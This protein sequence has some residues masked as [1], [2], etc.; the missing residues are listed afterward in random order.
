MSHRVLVTWAS[1]HGATAEIAGRVGE[2]LRAAGLEA[3]ARPVREVGGLGGYTAVVVGSAVYLGGWRKDAVRFLERHS[4]AL[5]E[6]PLWLFSSG[7]LGEGDAAELLEGWRHPEALEP[8]MER[9]GPRDVALFHGSLETAKLGFLER[10]M[11]RRVEVP[12]GDFRDW[13]AIAAWAEGIA[14][15]LKGPAA[16]G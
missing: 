5:A 11:V 4:E 3:D 14:A 9:L 16:G 10:F 15:D 1:K 2:V 6:R 8:M 12:V 13:E 7:P